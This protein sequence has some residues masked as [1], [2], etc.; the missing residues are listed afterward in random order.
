MCRLSTIVRNFDGCPILEKTCSFF[1][2]FN[3]PFSFN[4]F[5]F[6]SS[7]HIFCFRTSC[8][9]HLNPGPGDRKRLL[10]AVAFEK[11]KKEKKMK[12]RKKKII[13]IIICLYPLF[14]KSNRVRA[15]QNARTRLV[16]NIP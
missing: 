14:R 9:R 13:I 1:S 7:M 16:H 3:Q 11:K 5:S 4:S 15:F 10:I 12:Q 2:S 6:K 8:K